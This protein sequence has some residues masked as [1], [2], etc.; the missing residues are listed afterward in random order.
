M[1]LR[2]KACFITFEGA[3]GSGKTTQI[4]RAVAYL[5]GKGHRILFLREPGGTPISEAIRGVI[6]DSKNK[7]MTA[8][9]ELLL[10]LAARAQIVREKILPALGKGQIVVCD[11]FE[12][13]TLAYQGFGRR[14]PLR[15]ILEMSRFVRGSLKPNLTFV[16][17][18]ESREGLRRA[19]RQ[20][21]MEKESLAFHRRVRGGFRMLV[22]KEPKR[23]VF[24]DGRQTRTAL[25]RQVR[26]KLD[27]IL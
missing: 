26:E 16:F 9:T 3:E 25:A 22:K 23:F 4:R 20:D 10:Y 2:K 24:L 18:L 27:R 6:L 13:S 14:I 1:G 5:R 17:D 19:G 15:I 7:E 8:E 21:R 11:R 12:D